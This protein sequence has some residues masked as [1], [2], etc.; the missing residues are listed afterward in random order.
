MLWV[1]AVYVLLLVA[2]AA[3]FRGAGL[4]GE[5]GYGSANNRA[6]GEWCNRSDQTVGKG[7]RQATSA[8][9]PALAL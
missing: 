8:P 5:E 4:R 9:A 7:C 6:G 3:Y 2:P 1:V